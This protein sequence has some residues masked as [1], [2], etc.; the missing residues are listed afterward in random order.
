MT[1]YLYPMRFNNLADD[2]YLRK[3][4]F[5]S[6]TIYMFWR[7]SA[8]GSPCST[9]C[10]IGSRLPC[11]LDLP[12]G[13]RETYNATM[14][15]GYAGTR[16]DYKYFVHFG[17]SPNYSCPSSWHVRPNAEVRVHFTV[18]DW[19]I[20]SSTYNIC[21]RECAWWSTPD[22]YDFTP[23]GGC[24]TGYRGVDEDHD[25]TLAN[26]ETTSLSDAEDIWDSMSEGVGS[27]PLEGS[28]NA[29]FAIAYGDF[30]ESSGAVCCTTTGHVIWHN[31]NCE[32]GYL[33]CGGINPATYNESY[34]YEIDK[35]TVQVQV[36]PSGGAWTNTEIWTKNSQGV[37]E[38][39]DSY[40]NAH[41]LELPALS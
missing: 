25:L 26:L 1:K 35:T 20:K 7:S 36:K 9:A 5:N 12:E 22:D 10:T 39:D 34:K 23:P 6:G 21:N 41:V 15:A 4:I 27:F 29:T 3:S 31:N 37:D 30:S 38:Y 13:H 28:R 17:G 8:E 24:G 18:A 2:A 33:E 11:D 19:Y 16:Y 14:T 32:T 40:Y